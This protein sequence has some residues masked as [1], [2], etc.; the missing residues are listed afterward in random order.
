MTTIEKINTGIQTY[1]SLQE[2]YRNT[3]RHAV[4]GSYK[5][6]ILYYYLYFNCK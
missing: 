2:V 6:N 4:I 3:L 5:I 1:F